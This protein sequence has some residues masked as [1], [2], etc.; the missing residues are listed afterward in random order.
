MPA[1]STAAM[2]L[3]LRKVSETL[4]EDVHAVMVLDQAGWH[5]AKRLVVPDNIT[6]VPLPPYSPELNPVERVWLFLRERFLSFR[7]FPDQTA[8]I[9]ACCRA[10]NALT[11][12]R[13]RIRSLCLQPWLTQINS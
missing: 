5:G 2:G 12:D 8:I 13:G 10:W 3:F 7:V 9:D 1:V 11:E 4:E 6:L